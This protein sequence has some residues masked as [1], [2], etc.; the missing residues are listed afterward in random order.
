[1][2]RGIDE[3]LWADWRRRLSRFPQWQGTVA[4][5]CQQEG[6]SVAAFYQ[7]RRK[8]ATTQAAGRTGKAAAVHANPTPQFLPVRIASVETAR[9]IEIELPNGVRVRVSLGANCTL[10][11]IIAAAAA[12]ATSDVATEVA[13]T[14]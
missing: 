11:S 4:A 3:G 9:P 7:W 10:E 14:C 13:R 8:L 1:M 2:G 5:F 12:A 6:V